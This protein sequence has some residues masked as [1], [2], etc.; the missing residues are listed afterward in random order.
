MVFPAD[1]LRPVTAHAHKGVFEVRLKFKKLRITHYWTNRRSLV[2]ILFP[3]NGKTLIWNLLSRNLLA[4]NKEIRAELMD[5]VFRT[6]Q[7]ELGRV[8]VNIPR[9]FHW[10]DRCFGLLASTFTH[11]TSITVQSQPEVLDR[12]VWI[13]PVW[14]DS[15]FIHYLT[16]HATSLRSLAY[17]VTWLANASVQALVQLIELARAV[18]TTAKKL[19]TLQFIWGDTYWVANKNTVGREYELRLDKGK[20]N[21]CVLEILQLSHAVRRTNRK[22]NLSFMS[23]RKARITTW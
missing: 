18:T 12:H 5:L 16:T 22:P 6:N 14:E 9:F 11:M 7:I 8:P 20:W 21:R 2:A 1:P 17:E 3:G 19:E 10:E 15:S 4:I 23:D 13:P